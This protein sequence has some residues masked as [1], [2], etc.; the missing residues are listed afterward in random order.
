MNGAIDLAKQSNRK[1]L[2]VIGA[3]WCIWC[4]VLDS[5]IIN[6]KVGSEQLNSK[7]VYV[8]INGSGDSYKKLIEKYGIQIGGFPTMVVYNPSS[9]KTLGYFLPSQMKSVAEVL[10]GANNL[11]SLKAIRYPWFPNANVGRKAF[12]S[13]IRLSVIANEN[14][15]LSERFRKTV[16][17]QFKNSGASPEAEAYYQQGM[18]NLLTYNWID[19]I[20]SFRKAILI[21]PDFVSAY[22]G[23][24]WAFT[25]VD[26]IS[27][28][29]PLQMAQEIAQRTDLKPSEL[30]W[31][32]FSRNSMCSDSQSCFNL[33]ITAKGNES[34]Q[35]KT[36][37]KAFELAMSERNFNALI[38]MNLFSYDKDAAVLF[39]NILKFQPNNIGAHHILTHIFEGANDYQRAVQH[40]KYAAD[41]AP[42]SAHAQHMYGHVLPKV[43]RWKEAVA[44]FEKA[45][46]IHQ[47]WM[48]QTGA[49]PEE[50]WH[51]RHNLDLL[52]HT[53][54]WLG[55]FS[56]AKK[57]WSTL[58]DLFGQDYCQTYALFLLIQGK[59][60]EGQA[61]LAKI[62]PTLLH[63]AS[64]HYA[65]WTAIMADP[66]NEKL[67]QT[68]LEKTVPYEISLDYLI[69]SVLKNDKNET[70]TELIKI[71]ITQGGFDS[72]SR[73]TMEAEV[74]AKLAELIG[75]KALAIAI[76]VTK[77]DV[78][79]VCKSSISK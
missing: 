79:F 42:D 59:I 27:P 58:C 44:Q 10:T 34:D 25:N 20:R 73:K 48:K 8:K 39:E 13:E 12:K 57:G 45:D 26:S 55:S 68:M 60:K 38:A 74:V 71:G 37:I 15:I 75:N 32:Q 61:L 2:M 66:T 33:G 70:I 18:F 63:Q 47:T 19:A 69:K 4:K 31:L 11:E 51:Y 49:T 21:S 41:L 53:Q 67:K 24:S 5:M 28:I 56:A 76:R 9:D 1:V 65:V 7:Y 22:L 43:N 46:R 40:A 3:D 78:G 62:A 77:Q 50:D 6:D 72:W 29:G 36:K 54:N 64:E 23:L 14:I 17:Q 35:E 30:A 52:S 16:D